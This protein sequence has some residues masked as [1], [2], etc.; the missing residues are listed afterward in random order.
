MVSRPKTQD[1]KRV[2]ISIKVSESEAEAIDAARGA[3]TRSAWGR[4]QMLAGLK[5]RARRQPEKRG[6]QIAPPNA[7][8]L[9]TTTTLPA[10][11]P[12]TRGNSYCDHPKGRRLK[13]L[14]N[15]C[16]TYVG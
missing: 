15:A 7:P 10:P 11:P 1:G 6:G 4:D 12:A 2:A 5:P 13:G 8:G 9:A 3:L 16:G 14:C